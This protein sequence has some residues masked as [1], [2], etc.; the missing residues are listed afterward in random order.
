MIEIQQARSELIDARLENIRLMREVTKWQALY[1]EALSARLSAE[2]MAL[3]YQL[4]N[5]AFNPFLAK[6]MDVP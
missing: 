2:V 4:I 3:N 6:K 1:Y 5:A